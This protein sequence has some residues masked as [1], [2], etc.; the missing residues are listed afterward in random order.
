MQRCGFVDTI[1]LQT[2][3]IAF[4]CRQ[5]F[6]HRPKW[7]SVQKA[8]QQIAA[9]QIDTISVVAR[10]HHLTLRNRVHRYHP[11]KLWTTLRN[12][13]I[14]EHFAH[15]VCFVPIEDFP[16]YR[17]RMERFPRDC[18]SWYK[19][20][21]KKHYKL[22]DHVEARVKDEGALS[23]KD[24]EDP[25]GKKRNGFWDLKPAKIA[26]DLL[27]NTGRL[28]VADRRGFQI[29]YD[30][31]ERVIPKKYLNKQVDQEAV[32]R[33]F[34][35]RN[36]DCL[37]I[38]T[39]KDLVEYIR[40][41]N[42]AL[43]LKGNRMKT[44]EPKLQILE[45]ED[46]VKPIEVTD[47][48]QPHYLLTRNL[49]L[50]E[51]I[52]DSNTPSSRAWFLNPFDNLIWNRDRIKR[53]FGIEVKLEAYTPKAQRQF[54]YYITPILWQNRLVGRIDPKADRAS[55]TLIIHS[56]ELNLSP[57]EMKEA[58]E[59]IRQELNRFK[60]FHELDT[61]QIKKTRP[62]SLKTALSA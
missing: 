44:I 28:A 61:M 23:S 29:Y 15:A 36:L 43:D 58:I 11:D 46:I 50:I 10:S 13:E 52:Q 26:L 54:G 41:S 27:W 35:E 32:W 6:E 56:M 30:L 42:F 25:S 51:H 19:G 31:P 60:K 17:H 3:Q 12:R 48:K 40:F 37:V 62:K 49:P 38:A 33:Y 9:V 21:L 45:D 39:P 57:E 5:G 24:F 14:F 7:S 20:L 2:F 8:I 22:M 59:P 47:I 16:Y 18:G 1:D 55:K 4:V 53:L 34:L